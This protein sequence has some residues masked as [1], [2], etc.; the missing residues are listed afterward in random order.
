MA[1]IATT[2][3]RTEWVDSLIDKHKTVVRIA[4]MLGVD[5]STASRWLKGAGEASPRFIGA[6]MVTFPIT[7]DDAFVCVV[8]EAEQ[9]RARIITRPTGKRVA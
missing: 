2:R 1:Q 8:E 5:K 6:A 9:R 7:F 3:V 4:E